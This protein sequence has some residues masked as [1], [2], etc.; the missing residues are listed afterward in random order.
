MMELTDEQIAK[1]T[2]EQVTAIEANPDAAAEIIKGMEKTP[3]TQDEPEQEEEGAANGEGEDEQEDEPEEE[4]EPVVLTKNGKGT[5]PY[6]KLKELR[7]QN[8]ELRAQ[9]Q[10]LQKTQADLKDLR[11]QQA[12]ANTPERR[13]ELQEQLVERIKTLKED[14]P[15]I[16][17]SL[18]SV[19][20]I[21]TDLSREIAED[22]ARMKKKAEEEEAERKR[23]E[24]EKQREIDEQVQ[25]AKENNPDLVHWEANDP[26]AWR[27]AMMQD[28]A[29]LAIPKWR[30]KSFDERF[31]EVVK[32]VRTIMPEASKPPSA[33]PDEKVKKEAKAKL[34][35]A[36]ARKPTTLS[37]IKGGANPA[38]EREQLE[39]LGPFELA[40]KLMKMPERQAAAMRA[41]L[42]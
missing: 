28:Q 26:D 11:E 24:E 12:K 6:E 1:L 40:A 25:E 20:E 10:S 8:A 41:D 42:D 5:I 14:F 27:E 29:L 33:E 23:I 21:I 32:R 39:N 34:D 7:V 15:D 3:E 19:N 31:V 18:D 2:P 35:K 4:E 38:S 13:K 9:L 16:G 17:S 30:K 37:D 22:K 36:T